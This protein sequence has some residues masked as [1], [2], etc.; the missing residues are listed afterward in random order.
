MKKI[1]MFFAAIAFATASVNAN[2]TMSLQQPKPAKKAMSC[3]VMKSG[4]MYYSANGKETPLKKEIVLKNGTE[5]MPNGTWKEKGMKAK[6]L[7]NDECVDVMGKF[8]ESHE[9][10]KSKS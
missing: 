5:I 6:M 2:S 3:Y 8:H 10:H 9:S 7:K 4:K 1:L